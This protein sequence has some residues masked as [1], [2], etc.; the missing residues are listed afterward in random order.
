MFE[1]EDMTFVGEKSINILPL[2][3]INN[4]T[5][6]KIEEDIPSSQQP[7]QTIAPQTILQPLT[8]LI[9]HTDVIVAGEWLFGGEHLITASWDHNANVY[10]LE[11]GKIVNTLSGHDDKLTHC[12]AHSSQKLVAT[13]SKDYTFR[14]WDFREP[15]Q[16]VAVFQG[17]NEFRIKKKF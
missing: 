13:A 17:H 11:S 10:D 2:F 9:G 15:I 3:S 16:S 12:N 14:L 7:L 8:R 4:S 5:D 6:E 1:G